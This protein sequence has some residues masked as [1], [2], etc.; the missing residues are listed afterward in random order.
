MQK[1]D[2]G[3]KI[4]R[5]LLRKQKTRQ[6]RRGAKGDEERG[7]KLTGLV[8]LPGCWNFVKSGGEIKKEG[9]GGHDE[10]EETCLRKRVPRNGVRCRQAGEM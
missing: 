1:I 2:G 4:Q 6:E 10:C 7:G 5:A 9:I 8:G 3:E